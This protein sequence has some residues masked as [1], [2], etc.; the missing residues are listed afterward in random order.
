MIAPLSVLH[1][2][3]SKFS[4]E[5]RFW[6]D[7]LEQQD[8]LGQSQVRGVLLESQLQ[9]DQEEMG[10]EAQGHVVVPTSPAASL[11][12]DQADDGN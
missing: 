2:I 3:E 5:V 6:Q 11:V 7:G 10:Q 1:N 4:V 9:A 8:G 12:V